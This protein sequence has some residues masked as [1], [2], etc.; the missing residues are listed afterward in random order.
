MDASSVSPTD[1]GGLVLLKGKVNLPKKD[2]TASHQNRRRM[3][4]QSSLCMVKEKL[5][6]TAGQGS[7]C[8]VRRSLAGQGSPW[9]V[10][11]SS[12]RSS[13][14]STQYLSR[15]SSGDFSRELDVPIALDVQGAG[16][17]RNQR[18]GRED[19][20]VRGTPRW[21]E[22]PHPDILR[23][24][25]LQPPCTFAP[26]ALHLLSLLIFATTRNGR[27]LP[28]SGRWRDR[29]RKTQ[30]PSTMSSTPVDWPSGH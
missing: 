21:I 8:P 3:R 10:R 30:K 11:R 5:L 2:E 18:L 20:A 1:L 19:E 6:R 9:P 13:R 27:P 7:P 28:R 23:L 14:S 4:T 16:A 22:P 15:S 17:R 25:E 24:N 29:G 26:E 12:T